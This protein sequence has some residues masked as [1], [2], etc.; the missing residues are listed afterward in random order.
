MTTRLEVIKESKEQ[1]TLKKT[2]Q[3]DPAVTQVVRELKSALITFLSYRSTVVH[4]EVQEKKNEGGR[5]RGGHM[6]L[7]Q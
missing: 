2:K 7:E 5:K 6:S 4:C 3:E 1:T